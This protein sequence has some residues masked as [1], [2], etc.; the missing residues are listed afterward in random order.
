M[1]FYQL[2]PKITILNN[3]T[4]IFIKDINNFS[5]YLNQSNIKTKYNN[6]SVAIHQICNFK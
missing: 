6:I 5:I 4:L 3:K 2:D 1:G